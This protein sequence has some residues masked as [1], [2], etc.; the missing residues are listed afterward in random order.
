M[1]SLFNVLG[2]NFDRT[3][4]SSHPGTKS[5]NKDMHMYHA[6]VKGLEIMDEPH[7]KDEVKTPIDKLTPEKLFATAEHYRK[8]VKL[9]CIHCARIVVRRM[10]S[11]KPYRKHIRKHILHRY[12]EDLQNPSVVVCLH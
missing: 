5:Q 2:D 1:C 4:T 12:S 11:L 10:P 7:M 9:F 6:Y 8:L 3:V